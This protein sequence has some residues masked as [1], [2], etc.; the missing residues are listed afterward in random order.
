M[1]KMGLD[2]FSGGAGA[3]AGNSPIRML[4]LDHI[5]TDPELEGLFSID[6][7]ILA[8]IIQ[9]INDN[10]YDRAEPVVVWKGRGVVVDGHTRLKA[11]AEAGLTE[12]PVV[13]KEFEDLNEA[14]WYAFRRQADRRNLTQAEIFRA[15]TEL[16]FRLSR[17]GSGRAAE[18]LAKRLG[19]S[20]SMIARARS[21]AARASDEVKT[22]VIAGELSVYQA[23]ETV[24]ERKKP[25]AAP[26]AAET[27]D[28]A[29]LEDSP[30]V[31]EADGGF[32]PDAPSPPPFGS[33]NDDG[34]DE[35]K[36]PKLPK[37]GGAGGSRKAG[38]SGFSFGG[39]RPSEWDAPDAGQKDR[40]SEEPDAGD[41]SVNAFVSDGG[42]PAEYDPPDVPFIEVIG[43]LRGERETDIADRLINEFIPEDERAD[44]KNLFAPY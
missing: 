25:D 14:K 42:Y 43:F 19:V 29:G 5:S 36:P 6:E 35:Y 33:L 27:E 31:E 23:Y 30:P 3:T 16:E 20:R 34:F 11:A 4:G 44:F 32:E 13:E 9:S 7:E 40:L 26:P 41:E 28:D 10:G 37:S 8:E 12:I 18:L 15:A 22:A 24:R 21:V 38:G 39:G 2:N 17:D 1:A